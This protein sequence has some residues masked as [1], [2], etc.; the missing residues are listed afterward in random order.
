[1]KIWRIRRGIGL[2]ELMLSLAIIAILLIMA[3]RYYQTASSN[4]SIN[5]AVDMTNAVRGAVRNFM[6]SNL[7]TSKFPTIADL[8]SGGYLPNSYSGSTANPF[9]GNICVAAAAATTCP[10]TAAPSAA[11]FSV[12]LTGLPTNSSICTSLYNRLKNT[13]SGPTENITN[14]CATGILTATYV[15]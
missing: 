2:L 13:L 7:N 1:M 14:N 8:V 10:T 15:Q 11:T 5:S 12:V 6:T 3:T 9:G 4:N